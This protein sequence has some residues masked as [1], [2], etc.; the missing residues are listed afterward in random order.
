MTTE[1]E[2]LSESGVTVT[3]ARVVIDNQVYALS[4]ITSVRAESVP[5]PTGI[6]TVLL[7]IGALFALSA[8]AA[9]TF[10]AGAT[11]LAIAAVFFVPGILLLRGSLPTLYLVITT[12]AGEARA[13]KSQDAARIN[14]V[15]AAISRA[16][17]ER[18]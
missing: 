16:I 5:A 4:G 15:H 13:I 2:F 18:G 11:R 10:S 3:S 14:R 8:F 1:R 9:E 7:V 17:V 6:P 12:A